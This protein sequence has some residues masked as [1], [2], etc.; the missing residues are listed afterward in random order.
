VSL[1]WRVLLVTAETD[2]HELVGDV[3]TLICG[4]RASA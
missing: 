1:G 4:E 3:T 2:V